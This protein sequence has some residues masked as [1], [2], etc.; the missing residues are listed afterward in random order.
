[1][2]EQEFIDECNSCQTAQRAAELLRVAVDIAADHERITKIAYRL[3]ERIEQEREQSKATISQYEEQVKRLSEQVYDL[4]AELEDKRIQLAELGSLSALIG[5]LVAVTV[6]SEAATDKLCAVVERI[7]QTDKPAP[8]NQD[9]PKSKSKKQ[10]S[11]KTDSKEQR[12]KYGEYKH[13]LLT[14]TQYARLVNEFGA[15]KTDEYIRKVDEYCQQ[16]GKRYN[17]YN[18]TIRKFMRDDAAA[19]PAEQSDSGGHSYDL[20]KLINHAKNQFR[21]DKSES[22]KSEG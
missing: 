6:Q 17:D 20:D 19:K 21:G 7:E 12:S 3:K 2:T 8:Q 9:K 14:G 22:K 11:K 10:V 18:L 13:V 5:R 1:M 15:K 4:T 16:S